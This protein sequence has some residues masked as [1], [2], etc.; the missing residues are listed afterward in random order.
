MKPRDLLLRCYANRDG[1]Q[2]QAFCIDLCLAA[3]GESF[4]E[5]RHKLECMAEEYIYDALADED[6]EYAEE[7]LS[8]KAPLYQRLTYHYYR[9]MHHLGMLRDHF[10][11]R[12]KYPLPMVP[13]DHACA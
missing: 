10:H 2:W 8:R 1:D 9:V 5:A 4:Q 12:F 3:Q 13:R 6:R 7:L 11:K